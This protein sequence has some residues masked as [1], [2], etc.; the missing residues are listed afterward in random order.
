[1]AL[2]LSSPYSLAT[3]MG[4]LA[5]KTIT[6]SSCLAQDSGEAL[7]METMFAT[8]PSCLAQESM[9]VAEELGERDNLA[10]DNNIDIELPSPYGINDDSTSMPPPILFNDADTAIINAAHTKQMRGLKKRK[11]KHC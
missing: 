2:N 7:A 3:E 9:E 6:T 11:R 8:T 5:M 10:G 4:N 1:M